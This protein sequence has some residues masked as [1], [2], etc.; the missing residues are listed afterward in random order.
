MRS[1]RSRP[2]EPAITRPRRLARVFVA[3]VSIIR[4]ILMI[5]LADITEAAS[6]VRRVARV[7]PLIDVSSIAGR[8]LLLKCESLQPGGAFKIRGA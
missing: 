1:Q 2:L 7:T 5:T 4:S 8:P 6:R 3:F